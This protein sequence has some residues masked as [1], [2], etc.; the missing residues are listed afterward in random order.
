MTKRTFT[1]ARN[2]AA[3]FTFAYYQQRRRAPFDHAMRTGKAGQA[4]ETGT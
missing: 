2:A 4:E 3:I 1:T